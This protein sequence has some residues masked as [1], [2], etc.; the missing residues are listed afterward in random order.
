VADVAQTPTALLGIRILTGP[1]PAVLFLL[2]NLAVF[3]YPLTQQFVQ[4]IAAEN[5]AD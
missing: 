1:I 2:G 4:K 3:A 5:P